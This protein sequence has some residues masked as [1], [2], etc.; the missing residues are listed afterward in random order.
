MHRQILLNDLDISS[1]HL[2][3]LM[4]DMGA[5]QT[6]TQHFIDEDQLTV[7]SDLASF[8]NLTVKLRSTLRVRPI[9]IL[10]LYVPS[11]H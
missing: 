9:S 7:K 10:L 5:S 11:C 4:R 6:I 8:A 1:S 3:R 2:E